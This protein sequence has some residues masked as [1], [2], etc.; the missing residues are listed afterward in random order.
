MRSFGW[1]AGLS[2]GALFVF[3]IG[4]FIPVPGIDLEKLKAFFEE[5]GSGVVG[6]GV[7]DRVMSCFFPHW[8][9]PT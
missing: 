4:T 2:S 8:P 3:R 7:G 5:G 9:E 6:F 1:D